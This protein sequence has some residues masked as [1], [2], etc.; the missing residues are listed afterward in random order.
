MSYG[1]ISYILFAGLIV[2]LAAVSMLLWS[3]AWTLLVLIL[4]AF[5]IILIKNPELSL[6]IQFVGMP[7]YFYILDKSAIESTSTMTVMFYG[8]LAT[9][10]LSGGLLLRRGAGMIA[11]T[12]I[13]NLFVLVFMMFYVSYFMFSLNNPNAFRKVSLAPLAVIAPYIGIQMLS[14]IQQIDRFFKWCVIIGVSMIPLSLYELIINPLYEEYGRFSL[15]Y[16]EEKGNNPIQYGIAFGLLLLVLIIR[17]E[18][19]A[20][21]R[22]YYVVVL[23]L[24]LYLLIRSG[25]RGPFISFIIAIIAYV[26]FVSGLRMKYR[27][28]ILSGVGVMALMVFLFIPET[29]TLFYQVLVDPASSQFQDPAQDSIQSRMMLMREAY[30]E[31]IGN[32]V[33]GVG[34]GNSSGGTGYPHN[35]LLEVAAEYGL[36]G[37]AI[38]LSFIHQVFKYGRRMIRGAIDPVT[39]KVAHLTFILTLFAFTESLFSGYMG[40]DMLLYGSVGLLSAVYK[41]K[42]NDERDYMRRRYAEMK[43]SFVF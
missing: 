5:F 27:L 40:G 2:A 31:F 37:M 6:A 24:S 4:A 11:R 35:S 7:L 20:V 18:W 10:Y 12:G 29:T 16:F 39:G 15:Y 33:Y 43:E 17:K 8:Y 19:T 13:D 34:T 32:P 38:Y 9:S 1:K 25:A 28:A 30:S 41:I 36:L 42:I 3:A 23:G 22:Y 26:I 21:K 14:N